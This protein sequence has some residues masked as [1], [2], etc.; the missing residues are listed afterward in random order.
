MW[1]WIH[2]FDSLLFLDFYYG[3][4]DAPSVLIF[5]I[6][7]T[8]F[9]RG[10]IKTCKTFSFLLILLIANVLAFANPVEKRH[11]SQYGEVA[12]RQKAATLCP[13]AMNSA[14][15][16]V[17]YLGDSQHPLLAILNFDHGFLVLAGDDAVEPVLAYSFDGNFDYA[18]AAPGALFLLEEYQNDIRAVRESEQQAAPDVAA[19]WNALKDRGVNDETVEMVSP[20]ITARWNQ[21]KYYNAYSPID[22]ESPGGYDAR[23]PNGCVAVAMAMILY[24]YRYPTQ[25][26]GSHTNYTDYGNFY[27]NFGQQ[28]YC[29]EV[30][31]DQLN[32]YNNEVA[33]LIFHCATSVDMHYA[34]DGSGAY[35][36]DVPNAMVTYFGY[37]NSCNYQSKHNYSSTQWIQKLKN[38]LDV[39]RPVY[40]SGYSNEG[41][42]AF[43]CDGYN[44]D[45]L[46]HFNFGWGGTS[47]GYYTVRSSGSNP[48]NGYGSGQS[49]I[50]GL[51]PPET[52]YPYYCTTR[53]IHA[54]SGTLEDG[55]G[56]LDYA[57]NSNCSYLIAAEN[58]NFVTINIQAFDT[59]EG[60]D[61][62]SIYDKNDSLLLSLSGSK[63]EVTT[64]NFNTDSLLIVFVSDDSVTASGWRLSYDFH[65]NIQICNSGLHVEDTGTIVDGSGSLQYAPNMECT[66]V[67]N[68]HD[69]TAITFSFDSLDISPE[70][71]LYF[72][73]IGVN[74]SELVKEVSG[75]EIPEDFTIPSRKVHVTFHS[76]NYLSGDGFK[77]NWR[78][79]G[80][81]SIAERNTGQ[82]QLFPNPVKDKV[83]LQ[84]PQ[85]SGE[86]LVRVYDMAG[87]MLLQR[88]FGDQE[89]CEMD[90]SSLNN[91]I[92]MVVCQNDNLIYEKKMVVS[93]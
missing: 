42:H 28:R 64:Y 46:M 3:N 69:V 19:Q 51:Y 61:S 93:R 80:E 49:A 30:M 33:K 78:A 58:A 14:L 25:G 57:N 41:G 92:Y 87:R 13:A 81:S 17:Q 48:V 4:K 67:L 39:G 5:F 18:T 68:I 36:G 26:S 1:I 12:F 52:Q 75:S 7:A 79:H 45:N 9:F 65:R 37:K 71:K 44:S 90:V 15:K 70:D 43:V 77:L 32:H 27:V 55:S 73:N 54:E 83:H 2:C 20:L 31:E 82:V 22:Y 21:N 91:G 10:M 76:D 47:N 24:Y 86:T 66:W 16:D 40:Y 72:F 84:M 60:Q 8:L 23:T 29:Y 11:L 63:P 89:S 53:E 6:F 85:T 34:A 74:P 35:S 38:D 50:F 88:T 56:N 62:L 59:Q